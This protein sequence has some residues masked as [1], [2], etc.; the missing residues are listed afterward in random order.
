MPSDARVIKTLGDE[1][2]VV[3]SDPAA[4]TGW[5]VGLQSAI[6]PGEPP[7]RIGVHYG[8]ALYR[9]GD[10]YGRDVNQAARV[11]AR[12]QGGEVLVTRAVV[13]AVGVDG[14]EFDLIGEV[15]LK[16]FSEATELFI[17]SSR[18]T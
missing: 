7:S 8:E 15:R 6:A 5:A 10:Y 1:V 14:L 18:K 13:E 11:V 2:M 17:A 16:G 3:G 4:L 9:D 12:A